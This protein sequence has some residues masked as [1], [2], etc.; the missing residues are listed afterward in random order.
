MTTKELAVLLYGAPIGTLRSDRN[1]KL[2]FEYLEKA[3]ASRNTVPLSLSLPLARREH[4]HEAVESFLWGLLPDNENVLSRWARE[5]HISSRNP[6]ALLAH[7]GED[8]AGAVQIVAPER[9]HEIEGPGP[10]KVGWLTKSN[11]AERL[12]TL[13][14]DETAW[15]RAD[16]EGRFS[17]AGA[18]PKI[19]LFYELGRWGIPIGRTPTTH[20]L[21]PPTGAFHGQIENEH[22]CLQ[23]AQALGLPVAHSTIVRFGDETAIAVERYDRVRM[24]PEMA[25]AMA[26]SAAANAAEAAVRAADPANELDPAAASEAAMEAADAAARAAGFSQLAETQPVLRLHQEDMCQALGVRPH[27]K[28][29]NEGG[30]S[31]EQIADLLREHSD[32][33]EQDV[34]TF[35]DAILFNWLIGGSD[36]HAK[37][38]SILHAAGGRVRLAPLYDLA[39]ALPY[40]SLNTPRLKLAMKIGGHYRLQDIGVR[41]LRKLANGMGRSE[42][43]AIQRATELS[44]RL[45]QTAEH[46]L[47]KC[48]RG[49]LDHPILEQLVNALGVHA[50]R[51]RKRL[52]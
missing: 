28:Y 5:R 29:Q 49:G 25:A 3:R 38:Y 23:L 47:A 45:P 15:S 21:K 9:S 50:R 13:R 27:A 19:A 24:T 4:A 36:G 39:S 1:A 42:D 31:P 52:E 35:W 46:V 12:R 8:C 16:D 7:V 18:Q 20:I 6:F 11:V 10:V 40:P 43:D 32:A 37:N 33:P 26:A 41:E 48:R 2:T 22:F 30:P 14:S 17:L 34:A 44:T 51:C